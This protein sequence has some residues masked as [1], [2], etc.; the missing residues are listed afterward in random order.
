MHGKN[1][2]GV[3]GGSSG[4]SSV[5]RFGSEDPHKHQRNS[6]IIIMQTLFPPTFVNFFLFPNVWERLQAKS[7]NW[8]MPELLQLLTPIMSLE[9]MEDAE[10]TYFCKSCQ[11]IFILRRGINSPPSQFEKM[12]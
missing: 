2:A 3:D 12:L 5:R 7:L 11:S 1:S 8:F 9:D 6:P 4:G 10:E